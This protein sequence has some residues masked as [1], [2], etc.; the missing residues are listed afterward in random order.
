MRRHEPRFRFVNNKSSQ[1]SFS[2]KSR[3]QWDK[4]LH[5]ESSVRVK[6]RDF[7]VIIY[8]RNTFVEALYIPLFYMTRT[9]KLISRSSP[10]MGR[11]KT[12][13]LASMNLCRLPVIP[14]SGFKCNIAVYKGLLDNGR[15]L[16][17]LWWISRFRETL[18]GV[19][20]FL[21]KQRPNYAAIPAGNLLHLIRI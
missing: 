21:S 17:L 18:F 19:S 3:G 12:R 16:T 9:H 1:W 15:M 7:I 4:A 6:S 5:K 2:W 20:Q 13:T 8:L 14:T 10:R 11:W